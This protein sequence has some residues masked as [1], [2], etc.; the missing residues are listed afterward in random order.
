MPTLQE[1]TLAHSRRLSEIYQTR[2]VRIAQ[3]QSLRDLHLRGLPSAAKIYGKYDDELSVAREK[4]IAIEAKAAAA[5]SA[6]LLGAVDRRSDRFEDAQM[7]RRATDTEAVASKRRAEDTAN[8]KYEAAITNLRD[9]PP[10]SRERAA[11]DAERTRRVELEA[12]RKTHDEA[13][14]D[15]QKTYRESMD[16]A[17]LEERRESRDAE[18]AYL[19]AVQL[20][21]GAMRGA[22]T[23]AD[24]SLAAALA[25]NPEAAGILR[26][27]RAELATIVKETTE[28][29][30]EA[31]SRF[32]RD[33]DALK[34]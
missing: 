8:R 15:A 30:K 34:T 23:F 32:R 25:K 28:G 18:R 20:A 2:D 5:R 17:L 9:V 22:K 29:E 10:A 31:F 12:A 19:D 3:A 4:R 26:S 11:Q 6:A 7:S 27:W 24:Q 1:V 33:L 14:M 21:E 13:L 16:G